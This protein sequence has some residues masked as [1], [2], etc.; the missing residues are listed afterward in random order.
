MNSRACFDICRCKQAHSGFVPNHLVLLTAAAAALIFF[1]GI[2][3][4]SAQNGKPIQSVAELQQKL[5]AQVTAP[6][7]AGASWGVKVIS[8][9][10]GKTL[11]EHNPQKLFSPAS[12]AKLYTVAAAL[13]Q[14]GG[15]YRIRTSLYATA[16]PD[17]RGTLKGDLI[18]YGRGAPDFNARRHDGDILRAFEPLVAALTN[19]GVKRIRGDLVGDESFF[20]G[21]PFGS[22]WAWDDAQ[23]YYGAE[24]SALTANDN[25]LELA[26][27]PG[28]RVGAPCQLKLSPAT[29]Y[30]VLSNRTET[31]ATGSRTN[32]TL[33]RPPGDNVT[34]VLGTMP[35]DCKGTKEEVTVSNPA[36]LFMTFFAEALARHGIKVT[37][38]IRTVNW[39]SPARRA[40]EPVGGNAGHQRTGAET[41]APLVELGVVESL[42]LREFALEIQKPS[43]NLY[44]DL[45]LAHL[46]EVK[47]R[48][49]IPRGSSDGSQRATP[50]SGA[51][52][53]TSEDVGGRALREFARKAGIRAEDFH[54]EEGSGLSRNNLTTPAATI[55]LLQFMDRHPEGAAYRAALPLA[56]A[57]GTLRSRFKSTPAERNVQAKTGTLR[58]A[59]S[60]SGYLRTAAGERLAFC[61]MLNRYDAPDNERSARREI[62]ALTLLLVSLA[63][64]SGS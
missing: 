18:V 55:A 4:A 49:L 8:L 11:F 36:R 51:P 2:S 15:D 7:F 31:V 9:D 1:A 33:Y 34:Y 58:W 14:L 32:I 22:G 59:N 20:R 29:S 41:G 57:D 12:N 56:G 62:D 44:T 61:I 27:T 46:G 40:S 63:T 47:R 19:A 17:Q 60:L 38:K 26:I 16:P 54:F 35:Q 30:A 52:N 25:Y 21:P 42:P 24:I 28:D 23:Y 6:H 10:S 13:D 48:G 53:Q 5:T 64:P 3:S 39:L 45:L 50:P 43:Q 37:G